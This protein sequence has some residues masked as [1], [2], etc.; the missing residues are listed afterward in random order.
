MQWEGAQQLRSGVVGTDQ[1]HQGDPGGSLWGKPRSDEGVLTRWCLALGIDYDRPGET[2]RLPS[3]WN[4][5]PES[6]T[7][8]GDPVAEQVVHILPKVKASRAAQVV[9]NMPVVTSDMP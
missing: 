9:K 4:G 3:E 7:G 2:S 1:C 6:S 5:V 8:A